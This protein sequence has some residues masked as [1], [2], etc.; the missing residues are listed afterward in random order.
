MEWW[1][2]GIMLGGRQRKGNVGIVEDWKG[3]YW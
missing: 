3:E 1:K 2:A